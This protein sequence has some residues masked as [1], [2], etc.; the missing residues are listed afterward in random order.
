[1]Y[2]V[3][4]SYMYIYM[5]Y[6]SIYNTISPYH[7]FLFIFF[8]LFTFTSFK[9]FLYQLQLKYKHNTVHFSSSTLKIVVCLFAN[10]PHCA[11]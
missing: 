11:M 5:L 6:A 7:I 4:L 8:F 9:L 2:I 3:Y 1:M 10:L